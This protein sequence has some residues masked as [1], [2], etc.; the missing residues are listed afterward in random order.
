MEK[1]YDIVNGMHFGDI[2]FY[3]D[4]LDQ[5]TLPSRLLKI[6]EDTLVEGTLHI[7]TVTDPDGN[8]YSR[9]DYDDMLLLGEAGSTVIVTFET[10][11]P[12]TKFYW[13]EVVGGE[14][15]YY[16]PGSYE[17]TLPPEV[18]TE[19]LGTF[20]AEL[21]VEA[22]LGVDSEISYTLNVDFFRNED[23]ADIENREG[24]DFFIGTPGIDKVIYDKPGADVEVIVRDGKVYISSN[25]EIDELD[26]I[27]RVQFSDGNIAFDLDE[28]GNASKAAKLLGAVFGQ[29]KNGEKIDPTFAGIGLDY[30]DKGTSYEDLTE[31][32]LRARGAVTNDDVVNIL[33]ENIVG[34]APSADEGAPFVELLEN[35][36]YTWGTL[37]VFAADL[38]LN[39]QNI[40]LSGLA[41]SG[42]EYVEIA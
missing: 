10:S 33:F 14:F 17:F 35:E 5:Y 41:Q 31:L 13:H 19:Y 39:E 22:F 7:M 34:R 16:L 9:Y 12:N 36:V 30:L 38:E 32:A 3:D 25:G 29:G 4:L 11:N 37:G 8:R 24:N 1:I 15:V 27:E 23:L 6:T 28:N 21:G 26:G 18:T 42:L 20:S 2:E 40:N